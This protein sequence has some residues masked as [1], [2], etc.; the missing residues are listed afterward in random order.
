MQHS[1]LSGLSAVGETRIAHSSALRARGLAWF[2]V[3]LL[4]TADRSASPLGRDRRQRKLHRREEGKRGKQV[5]DH[6]PCS[7]S[8]G[9]VVVHPR[10]ATRCWQRNILP[11]ST[12]PARNRLRNPHGTCCGASLFEGL[13]QRGTTMAD[14]GWFQHIRAPESTL[15]P[16]GS[17]LWAHN[18]RLRDSAGSSKRLMTTI[19]IDRE[20]W[21]GLN[22]LWTRDGLQYPP[23]SF[24][25]SLPR[26]NCRQ[27]RSLR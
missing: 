7:N 4:G 14:F 24:L 19:C 8:P 23:P 27:S 2:L 25:Y 13:Y 16:V 12:Q 10:D 11:R 22:P 26:I 3:A 1:G 5:F 18:W 20:P 15:I 17:R 9:T 6:E 21:R